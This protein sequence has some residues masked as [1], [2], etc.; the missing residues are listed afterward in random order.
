MPGRERFSYR[1]SKEINGS[2]MRKNTVPCASY[3][4]CVFIV[5][6]ILMG[7][8]T[9]ITTHA[10][11]E[12][13]DDQILNVVGP[14]LL[15]AGGLFF[16]GAVA[17]CVVAC[18]TNNRLQEEFSEDFLNIGAST[19][20]GGRGFAYLVNED[21]LQ[22]T[23]SA[24][25][26]MQIHNGGITNLV[27]PV[28]TRTSQTEGVMFLANTVAEERN[29]QRKYSRRYAR[30]NTVAPD[31]PENISNCDHLH[32]NHYNPQLLDQHDHLGLE[33]LRRADP[34]PELARDFDLGEAHLTP[35]LR[36][37]SS[38][39]L[40]RPQGPP[41]VLVPHRLRRNVTYSAASRARVHSK[42]RHLRHQ[43]DQTPPNLSSDSSPKWIRR[44]SQKRAVDRT[45]PS[46]TPENIKIHQLPHY[47]PGL[48][49][50]LGIANTQFKQTGIDSNLDRNHLIPKTLLQVEHNFQE[51]S[52]G[53]LGRPPRRPAVIMG[54]QGL[55]QQ[56]SGPAYRHKSAIYASDMSLH[57]LKDCVIVGE[58][59]SEG[60]SEHRTG[61]PPLPPHRGGR[62]I[63]VSRSF[64]TGNNY[65]HS[66]NQLVNIK[67]V[68]LF[69]TGSA[70]E[71]ENIKKGPSSRWS[72]SS[73]SL[74]GK[75]NIIQHDSSS[76]P[77][78]SPISSCSGSPC[79][80]NTS[81]QFCCSGCEAENESKAREVEGEEL[82]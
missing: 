11:E 41:R 72:S 57:P 78:Q 64:T 46:G 63:P 79:N 5:G 21:Q 42:N 30:N 17:V 48:L 24:L 31:S 65:T 32:M 23:N 45:P 40:H 43:R 56:P 16:F 8:G 74:Q 60:V 81:L 10:L 26:P 7:V 28:A 9:F 15:G 35:V 13:E 34:Y 67:R 68:Q 76:S 6:V 18:C 62:R 71:I 25:N 2:Y 29:R 77:P 55:N 82:N 69:S 53:S 22:Q 33:K 12:H 38:S 19:F 47:D 14:V 1:Q 66:L 50:S 75:G 44:L 36:D 49:K 20:Y 73:S 37:R 54:I 70:S 27:G 39:V 61:R 51:T 80:S 4:L 3:V 59:A 58:V 52:P